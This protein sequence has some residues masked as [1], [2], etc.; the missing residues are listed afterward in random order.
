VGPAGR[1]F[2]F[3]PHPGARHELGAMVARN[4]VASVVE[5][6]PL[7]LADRD[8]EAALH[9]SDEFTSYSTLDPSA[10]PMRASATFVESIA[11]RM[12]S[13]DR[14]LAD[15]PEVRDRIRCVKID[16]EGTEAAAI[17][18][19]RDALARLDVRIIC[20][21]SVGSAADLALLA[22]GFAR[23]PIEPGPYG[24]HLYLRDASGVR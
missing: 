14:W 12:T 24:N 19:M 9:L 10:S 8:G 17:A 20:E 3:E 21:T 1:V 18:G 23:R 4:D 11:I 6:V 15:R 13:F 16:V 5:I 7:A 22:C 2:A